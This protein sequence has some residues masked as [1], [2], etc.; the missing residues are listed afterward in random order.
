MRIIVRTHNTWYSAC[1][2]QWYAKV[3]SS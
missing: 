1:G 3:C 2:F